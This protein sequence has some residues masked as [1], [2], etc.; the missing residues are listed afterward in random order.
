[1][2]KILIMVAQLINYIVG[3][4]SREN[5][6]FCPQI[7]QYATKH[8]IPLNSSVSGRSSGTVKGTL[9]AGHEQR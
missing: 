5:L 1:M 6:S 9:H 7:G 2:H 4:V 8:G 3:V